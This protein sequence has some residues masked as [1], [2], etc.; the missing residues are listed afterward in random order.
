MLAGCGSRKLESAGFA[1]GFGGGFTCGFRGGL[2]GGAADGFGGGFICGFAR[3]FGFAC[4]KG[5][6]AEFPGYLAEH[7]DEEFSVGSAQIHAEKHAAQLLLGG[8]GAASDVSAGAQDFEED[9]REAFEV[10]GGGRDRIG[11]CESWLCDVRLR[12]S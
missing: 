10:A 6:Q 1:G 3:G 12:D 7:S 4:T 2:G 5:G 11:V 8:G 9:L